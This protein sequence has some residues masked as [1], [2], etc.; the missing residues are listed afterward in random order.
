MVQKIMKKI[1]ALFIEEWVWRMF[2]VLQIAG[3][4]GIVVLDVA[5]RDWQFLPYFALVSGD[6]RWDLINKSGFNW[7]G[8][9]FNWYALFML[10]GPFAISKGIDW[11][12]GAKSKN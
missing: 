2:I 3:L 8:D 10:F 6:L 1:R 11:V 4:V 9:Y 12:L 5:S 7:Y